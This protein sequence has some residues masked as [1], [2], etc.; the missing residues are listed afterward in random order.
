[1]QMLF[2]HVTDYIQLNFQ[3]VLPVSEAM[4]FMDAW[5]LLKLKFRQV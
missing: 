5:L 4:P 2:I 1:M 3:A